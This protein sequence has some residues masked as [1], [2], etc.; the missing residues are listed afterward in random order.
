[1][2]SDTASQRPPTPAKRAGLP[3]TRVA[4][5]AVGGWG[6]DF[7]ET[8]RDTDTANCLARMMPDAPPAVWTTFV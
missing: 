8:E 5:S 3:A 4:R 6:S 1:M 7:Q 2:I